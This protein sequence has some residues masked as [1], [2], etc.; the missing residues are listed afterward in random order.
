M[1]MKMGSSSRV[2]M[3]A[4]LNTAPSPAVTLPENASPVRKVAIIAG[5]MT[6]F[7][8]MTR[9]DQH[10]EAEQVHPVRNGH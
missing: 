5:A 1:M 2:P 9:D 4:A 3:I 10:D 7:L 6:F 8:A